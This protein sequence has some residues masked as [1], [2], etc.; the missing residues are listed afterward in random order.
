MSSHH[1]RTFRRMVLSGM[2]G[3]PG[4]YGCPLHPTQ[5]T[6]FPPK[7]SFPPTKQRVKSENSNEREPENI[8]PFY[9]EC[10]QESSE[11]TEQRCRSSNRSSTRSKRRSSRGKPGVENDNGD[12]GSSYTTAKAVNPPSETRK[13]SWRESRFPCT[14]SVLFVAVVCCRCL[15]FVS[16]KGDLYDRMT[17][18]APY[19]QTRICWDET[20]STADFFLILPSPSPFA[21]SAGEK[22][23]RGRER[24]RGGGGVE[25]IECDNERGRVCVSACARRSALLPWA[26]CKRLLHFWYFFHLFVT[27][28]IKKKSKINSETLRHTSGHHCPQLRI[29]HF[30]V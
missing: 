2:F 5:A 10:A 9:P 29:C 3:A 4:G 16:I 21:A 28:S 17:G 25:R 15:L 30:Q 8:L 20:R 27:L 1:I 19:Q 18:V 24:K 14:D 11:E 6:S 22:R 23:V 26:P 13:S 7:T 12:A